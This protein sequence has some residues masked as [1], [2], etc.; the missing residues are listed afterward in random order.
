MED[1]TAKTRRRGFCVYLLYIQGLGDGG[2]PEMK[3]RK[4]VKVFQV[5]C[6]RQGRPGLVIKA[7]LGADG[8]LRP[9]AANPGACHFSRKLLYPPKIAALMEHIRCLLLHEGQAPALLGERLEARLLVKGGNLNDIKERKMQGKNIKERRARKRSHTFLAEKEILVMG[10]RRTRARTT[11]VFKDRLDN[12]AH[13][14]PLRDERGPL[15]EKAFGRRAPRSSTSPPLRVRSY[16][17]LQVDAENPRNHCRFRRLLRDGLSNTEGDIPAGEELKASRRTPKR[18]AGP[19]PTAASAR[20]RR[21]AGIRI[22]AIGDY[23]AIPYTERDSR[24]LSFSKAM[25]EAP[26]QMAIGLPT[27]PAFQST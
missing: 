12:Y 23:W 5:P 17:S 8:C 7:I 11:P 3:Y 22:D 6:S 9:R 15:P 14:S 19:A 10:S 24:C 20:C 27:P 1:K 26:A 16:V 25:R 4:G 18:Y 21:C 13:M 2:K